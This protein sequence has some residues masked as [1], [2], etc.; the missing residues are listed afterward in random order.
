MKDDLIDL[1]KIHRINRQSRTAIK[2]IIDGEDCDTLQEHRIKQ[3]HIFGQ[4][5]VRDIDIFL[6]RLDMINLLATEKRP[7][8]ELSEVMDVLGIDTETTEQ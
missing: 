2:D 1:T 6:E 8:P 7:M 5:L 3:F 4:R